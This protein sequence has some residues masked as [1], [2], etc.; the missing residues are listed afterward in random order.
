MYDM[1]GKFNNEAASVL[2]T[3]LSNDVTLYHII[4]CH[5]ISK[6]YIGVERSDFAV[7]PIF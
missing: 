3:C 1:T 6:G 5:Y 4:R 2:V 7:F